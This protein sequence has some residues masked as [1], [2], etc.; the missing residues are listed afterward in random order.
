MAPRGSPRLGARIYFLMSKTSDSFTPLFGGFRAFFCRGIVVKHFCPE[1]YLFVYNKCYRV[2]L[3]TKRENGIPGSSTFV[4][5]WYTSYNFGQF[6]KLYFPF[7]YLDKEIKLA[8][9]EF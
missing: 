1:V 6:M 3:K 5:Y 8:V 7:G 9:N 4:I 2:E